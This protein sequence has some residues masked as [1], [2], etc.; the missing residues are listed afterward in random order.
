LT[1]LSPSLAASQIVVADYPLVHGHE[2]P[3]VD[4]EARLWV[5]IFLLG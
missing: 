3:R 4:I 5:T 1:K 2:G